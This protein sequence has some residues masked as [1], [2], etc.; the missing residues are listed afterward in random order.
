MNRLYNLDDMMSHHYIKDVL[1][2]VNDRGQLKDIDNLIALM[3][4]GKLKG[5]R[6]IKNLRS[7]SYK[8]LRDEWG[9]IS[10]EYA[11]NKHYLVKE[12]HN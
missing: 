2:V 7:F 10:L 4:I 11:R 9:L 12:G 5:H 6:S 3:I 8:K 1:K